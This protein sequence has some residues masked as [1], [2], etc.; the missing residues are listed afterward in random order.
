MKIAIDISQVIYQTGVSTY[1]KELVR[2]I[3]KVDKYNEYVLFGGS[4]RRMSELQSF[5][6]SLKGNFTTRFIPLP[7]TGADMLWNILHIGNIENF[8]GKVDVFHTSDW[9]QAPTKNAYSV[10]TVHDLTPLIM[11]EQ[12]HTKIVA[13]HKRR[14]KW[15]KKEVD[16]V[17]VPS[18]SALKD[19]IKM[20]VEKSK[21]VVIPEAPGVQFIQKSDKEVEKLKRKYGIKGKYLL[22]V[23]NAPRKNISRTIQAFLQSQNQTGI[24]RLVIVGRGDDPY[25]H[26][27]NVIFT[28]HV[29]EEDL[30]VFYSGAEALVYASL[31]EG[32]GLP[33]LEAFS[34][35]C[36]VL[37]SNTSSLPEV[38]GDAAVKVNPESIDSIAKG[39]VELIQNRKSLIQK[40]SHRVK[41]FNWEKTAKLTIEIYNQSRKL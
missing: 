13:T 8:I 35:K 29:P 32:F 38:A 11:P 28:G 25:L 37:I 1:T 19:M 23:G 40:G 6:D 41:E 34:C 14:L 9:A 4:L 22:A 7:P 24:E 30:P 36:P 3:L 15:I 16:R 5:A 10:T 33:V 2:N 39:I 20:G 17:I 21:V 26:S 18:Q 12:T 27:D 31:Y